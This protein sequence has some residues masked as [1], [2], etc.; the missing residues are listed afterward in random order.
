MLPYPARGDWNNDC[1]AIGQHHCLLGVFVAIDRWSA[2]TLVWSGQTWHRPQKWSWSLS[3][4][5]T[6]F[7]GCPFVAPLNS[8]PLL[9]GEGKSWQPLF[10]VAEKLHPIQHFPVS[11]PIAVLPILCPFTSCPLLFFLE[12]RQEGIDFDRVVARGSTTIHPMHLNLSSTMALLSTL[13]VCR[14]RMSMVRQ[15]SQLSISLCFGVEATHLLP[16]LCPL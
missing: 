6:Y 3:L 10:V 12:E 9:C 11:S 13:L 1:T 5:L 8:R 15:T 4:Q 14:G 16:G 2:E 7:F